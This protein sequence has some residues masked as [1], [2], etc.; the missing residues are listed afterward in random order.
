MNKLVKSGDIAVDRSGYR[1]EEGTSGATAP[2]GPIELNPTT[3]RRPDLAR[4]GPHDDPREPACRQRRRGRQ[5]LRSLDRASPAPREDVKLTNAA[6]FEVV[7]ARIVAT[8]RHVKVVE[9]F[10][11]QTFVPADPGGGGS[12]GSSGDA[13][14]LASDMLQMA[15]NVAAL[16]AHGRATTRCS[17]TRASGASRI[18]GV[19]LQRIRPLLV[20]G[21][22]ADDR[23]APAHIDPHE[24]GAG[25][26]R[27]PP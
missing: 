24:T 8:E 15:W 2:G 25:I 9:A 21:R 17:K 13:L 26:R 5:G 14:K 12:S 7:A 10:E 6:H 22:E 23:R 3:I 20:E 11:G 27:R 1:E 18:R 4:V 16:T 19:D